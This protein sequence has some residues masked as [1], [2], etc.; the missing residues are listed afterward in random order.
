MIFDL[1][2]VWKSALNG[3]KRKKGEWD[4]VPIRPFL[5]FA[6]PYLTNFIKLNRRVYLPSVRI[7]RS[8]KAK[9][10]PCSPLGFFSRLGE[11]TKEPINTRVHLGGFE[12]MFRSSVL[13]ADHRV[14]WRTKKGICKVLR[15]AVTEV[16]RMIRVFLSFRGG[17]LTDENQS[18]YCTST[19]SWFRCLT[20]SCTIGGGSIGLRSFSPKPHILACKGCWQTTSSYVL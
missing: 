2:S 18:T 3:K 19:G 4:I 13:S 9:Y 11:L 7:L 10:K 17:Q 5:Y 1:A 12:I 15:G 8:G 14:T 16:K 6:L 20:M